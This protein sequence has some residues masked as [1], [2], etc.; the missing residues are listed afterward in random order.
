MNSANE[1]SQLRRNSATAEKPV[2]IGT[3][4]RQK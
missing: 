3:N 1:S 4:S 2:D